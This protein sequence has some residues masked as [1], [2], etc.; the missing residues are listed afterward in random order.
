MVL[1]LTIGQTVGYQEYMSTNYSDTKILLDFFSG[2]HGHFLEYVIN[3]WIFN[4]PRVPDL[5]TA[6]G[7]SHGIK[8][9]EKYQQHKT[10]C[11]GHFT[12]FNKYSNTPD[13][14]IRITIGSD[15][16]RYIYQINVMF[17]AGD[18]PIGKKILNTNEMVRNTPRLYRNEWY[19]KFNFVENG[20]QLPGQWRWSNVPSFDFPMESLFDVVNFY[21]ELYRL[22]HYL[23]Q[24]FT[25]DKEL[26]TMFESFL[27]KNQGWQYWLKAKFIVEQSL[28]SKSMQFDS[29]SICQALINTLL[30]QCTGVF[31]GNL[32][33]H[34][35]YAN[36]TQQITQ[37]VE[38]HLITFDSKF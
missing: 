22:S 3:T 31:D 33:D 36:T 15:W 17:R 6:L 32:F 38:Q 18:L 13:K 28:A 37:A 19:S 5:F 26:S 30:S 24:S 27:D 8:T 11:C 34:N 25:P 10:V 1:V 29:D 9:H 21:K 2:S 4:G 12:E 14:L 16:A 20:Y 7:A 35:S 23:Q